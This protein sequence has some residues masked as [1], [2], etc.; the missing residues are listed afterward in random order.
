MYQIFIAQ[1][2]VQM[3]VNWIIIYGFL[4]WEKRLL[5]MQFRSYGLHSDIPISLLL[6]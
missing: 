3:R 2:M 6:C 1:N 4:H 5:R